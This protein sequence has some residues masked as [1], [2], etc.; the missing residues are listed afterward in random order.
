M[1]KH[2]QVIYITR[3]L[4]HCCLTVCTSGFSQDPIKHIL[5]VQLLRPVTQMGIRTGEGNT[6]D[7]PYPAAQVSF[8]TNSEVV[9]NIYLFLQS[10]V[11]YITVLKPFAQNQELCLSNLE[12][13]F[14]MYKEG[15]SSMI[16]YLCTICSTQPQL[17]VGLFLWYT[18]KSI[19]YYYH[20]SLS[21]LWILP[22][23]LRLFCPPQPTLEKNMQF[24]FGY[25]QIGNYSSSLLSTFK[26]LCAFG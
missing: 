17:I 7:H 8:V 24:F 25:Y 6:I 19:S 11:F 9:H 14:S 18:L 1:N 20:R 15:N 4:Y 22:Y 10:K 5:M 13:T 23:A 3:C 26:K 12:N 2:E 16:T 21:F